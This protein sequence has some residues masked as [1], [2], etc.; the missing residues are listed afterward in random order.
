MLR[1]T[2]PVKKLVSKEHPQVQRLFHD[3]VHRLSEATPQERHHLLTPVHSNKFQAAQVRWTMRANHKYRLLVDR[4]G[5][6][7][8]IRG[9]VGRG[10]Q[11][12]YR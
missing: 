8:V 6:E 11:R 7:F 4:E 2:N 12:F 5:D 10:N 1:I 3:A 9:F